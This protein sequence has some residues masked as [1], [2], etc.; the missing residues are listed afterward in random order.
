VAAPSRT[1]RAILR[2]EA[3]SRRLLA[4]YERALTAATQAKG[5]AHVLLDEADGLERALKGDQLRELHHA[6]AQAAAGTSR[7]TDG[8]SA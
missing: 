6:R 2:L 7:G 3:R 5:Q 4:R 1:V 8:G